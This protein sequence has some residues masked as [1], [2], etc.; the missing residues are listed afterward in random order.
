MYA[1]DQRILTKSES[2]LSQ[3]GVGLSVMNTIRDSG[4]STKLRRQIV[5]LRSSSR[6]I[7]INENY[8][9]GGKEA[10]WSSIFNEVTGD[11][12]RR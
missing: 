11:G 9:A 3:I 10:N 6:N 12:M 2:A 8:T 4:E 7:N 5:W 1:T